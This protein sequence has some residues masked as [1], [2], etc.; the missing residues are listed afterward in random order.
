MGSPGEWVVRD[1]L[2]GGKCEIREDLVNV[3]VK[4]GEESIWVAFLSISLYGSADK[5]LGQNKL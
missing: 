2:I 3:D 5:R 1:V 4:N